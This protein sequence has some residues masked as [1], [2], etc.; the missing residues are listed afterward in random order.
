[1]VLLK[2][3]L[4]L[5]F[6]SILYQDIKE[7]Q[8]YWFLF[9]LVGIFCGALFFYHT[10]PELFIS[11]VLMNLFFVGLLLLVTFV[12]AKVKLGTS[13]FNTIGLGDILLFLGLSVSFATV[14]F[15]VLFISALVFALILHL[16]IKRYKAVITV[17]LAGYMS[18]FFAVVYLSHWAGIIDNLYII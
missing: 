15:I 7:R 6:G 1:M 2:T 10:L 4:I 14:S 9:P 5:C 13:I 8:V 3:I 11:S 16:I 12:Y 17:P 18:L